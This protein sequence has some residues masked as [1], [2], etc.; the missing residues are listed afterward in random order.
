MFN[1]YHN[2]ND[3]IEEQ[4]YEW[5]GARTKLKATDAE[6]NMVRGLLELKMKVDRLLAKYENGEGWQMLCEMTGSFGPN[7]FISP[8]ASKVAM[9][10]ATL[11]AMCELVNK[12]EVEK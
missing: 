12:K 4:G 3:Y 2:I 10:A 6:E 9:N 5:P 11:Y 7:D 8:I 1:E